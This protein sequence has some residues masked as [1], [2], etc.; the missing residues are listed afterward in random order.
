MTGNW[1]GQVTR[2]G[3]NRL[4]GQDDRMTEKGGRE[5]VS[6]PSGILTS[7]G[8]PQGQ[9]HK[10]TMIEDFPISLDGKKRCFRAI[11]I[12]LQED[13]RDPLYRWVTKMYEILA[14][15]HK[16]YSPKRYE[17]PFFHVA[18]SPGCMN[19][20]SRMS[21][22][23]YFDLFSWFSVLFQGLSGIKHPR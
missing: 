22:D 21:F 1:T 14:K 16:W 18:Y 13:P 5:N 17:W 11:K 10:E 2:Q 4:M 23:Q 15:N 6:G 12:L 9:D 20:G 3:Q 8:N 19:V 7:F